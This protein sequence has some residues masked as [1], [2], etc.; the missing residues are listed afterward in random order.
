MKHILLML[1]ITTTACMQTKAQDSTK[2]IKTII[3][4][5]QYIFEPRNTTT[6][7]G[8]LKQLTPGYFLQV[9]GDTLKT[10]LPYFGK[11]YSASMNPSDAGFNF[12]STNF[13]YAVT[14]GKKKNYNIAIKTKDQ[15]YN[16]D[17]TVTV[18]DD[19]TA[20]LRANNTNRQPVS[21]NGNIKEKK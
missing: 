6:G 20:Y 7:N 3:D 16:T 1:C 13:T 19:G 18:Y 15:T 14:E 4:A 17:F 2:T 12:T 9:K 11:A 8:R 10:D 21:Y 5:K